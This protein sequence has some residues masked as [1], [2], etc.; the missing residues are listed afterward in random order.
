MQESEMETPVEAVGGVIEIPAIALPVE[1]SLPVSK[2]DTPF[3]SGLAARY[4]VANFG[5]SVVYGLFNQ[6]MPLYLQTYGI[7]PWLIGLLANERAFVGALVQ[8]VVGRLSDRTRTP[9]GRRKPFFL[10]GVPLMAISLF[11]L[12]VHPN[13]WLLLGLMTIGS[14]FLAVAQDPYIALLADLFPVQHRGKVGGFLGLTTALGLIGFSLL[15]SFLWKNNE[16]VVFAL[17]IA[18]LL[19][20][21]AFTF[22]MIKEPP[23][24]PHPISQK[25]E[26]FNLKLYVRELRNYPEAGK[27]IGSLS[28]F[29]LGAGGATP[30]VTLFGTQ[31]LHADEGQVF[32]LPLAFVVMS[33]IFSI[34]AGL[35]SDRIG[36]KRVMFIGLL[37]YG[38]GALI[39]SQAT[40]LMQA[41]IALAVVGLGNAGTAALNPLLTD[42]IPRSRTAELMGVGSAIWSFAQP[43]GSALAGVIVTVAA[44]AVGG[45]DAY[46]WAFIFA[47]VMIVLAAFSLRFV[48]PERVIHDEPVGEIGG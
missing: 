19:V 23:L 20:T 27:Y 41:T 2:A 33:A 8:P 46:R 21:Y 22:F 12:S 28:L 44:L 47:G 7:F 42:L 25:R 29:W 5:S 48:H 15:S 16:P 14:F 24:E 26:R 39:G 38:L 4:S 35:L 37:I 9:I 6:A 17:V 40:D 32:L 36:K 11:L 45:S 30:F 34:P 10:V 31:A 1:E 43:L 13:I 3:D 18:A